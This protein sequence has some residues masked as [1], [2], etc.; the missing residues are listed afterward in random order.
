SSSRELNPLGFTVT[1][2][3]TDREVRGE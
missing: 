3:Q 2:Y 1:S